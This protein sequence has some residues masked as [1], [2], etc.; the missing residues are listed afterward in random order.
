MS[1]SVAPRIIWN[2]I[3]LGLDNKQL[4]DEV[5]RSVLSGEAEG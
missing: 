2:L 5:E 1:F 3:K 4:L